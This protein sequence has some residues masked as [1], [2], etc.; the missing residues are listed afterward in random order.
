MKIIT[1]TILSVLLL[2]LSTN[3]ASAEQPSDRV[4][5]KEGVV[6]TFNVSGKVIDSAQALFEHEKVRTAGASLANLLVGI[7]GS[8]TVGEQS[9]IEIKRLGRNPVI[10]LERGS[11]KVSSVH[12]NIQIVTKFGSF[13][14]AEWPFSIELDN[15]TQA[16]NLAVNEGAVRVSRLVSSSTE[17]RCVPQG[18]TRD[19][20]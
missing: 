19:N 8:V 13:S 17:F 9:E 18:C 20:H 10:W 7:D 14:P 3:A 11:I 15:V 1:Q 5:V 6:E 12:T 16:T 2:S 4:A